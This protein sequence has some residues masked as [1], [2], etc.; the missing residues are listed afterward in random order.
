MSRYRHTNLDDEGMPLVD[1][2]AT[3]T[4]DDADLWFLP[5]PLEVEPDFLPPGPA[6]EA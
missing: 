4:Q 2:E 1:M 5:G 3:E 6:P